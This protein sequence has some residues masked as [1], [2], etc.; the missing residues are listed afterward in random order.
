MSLNYEIIDDFMPEHFHLD[1]K[2]YILDDSAL[3]WFLSHYVSA[4]SANDGT[5]FIHG[6]YEKFYHI[7]EQMHLFQPIIDKIN[8]QALIRFKANLYPGTET[9]KHHGWHVDPGDTKSR[10][11]LYYINSNNGKTILKGDDG[12]DDVIV[13]SVANRALF[14]ES[15]KPH[16]STTCTDAP[17]RVNLAVNYIPWD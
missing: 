5:Y 8:P 17:H 15:Y 12:E 2:K 3:R 11:V 4:E 7:S 13:D 1:A 10:G 6:F 14:F 9:T 16:R